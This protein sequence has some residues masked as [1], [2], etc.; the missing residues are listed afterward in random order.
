MSQCFTA[1]EPST[2]QTYKNNLETSDKQR[3]RLTVAK[4][5]KL[6]RLADI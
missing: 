5:N 3:E 6:Y 4:V 1:T 2:S